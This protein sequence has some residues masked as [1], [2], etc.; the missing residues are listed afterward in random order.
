MIPINQS[1]VNLPIKPSTTWESGIQMSFFG[2][3][4]QPFWPLKGS[5][6]TK[7]LKGATPVE[8][9]QHVHANME[10]S[11]RSGNASLMCLHVRCSL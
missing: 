11:S 8:P 4:V 7:Q 3:P 10:D 2:G 6:F 5:A 9:A 1:N